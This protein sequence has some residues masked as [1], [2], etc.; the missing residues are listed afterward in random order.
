MKS[1]K[2]SKCGKIKSFDE[3]YDS[4]VYLDGKS[5][6][7]KNCLLDIKR[8]YRL[9]KKGI[10]ETI[11][12]NQKNSCRRRKH[13][14]PTYTMKE[15]ELWLFD[16][17][18]FH[19]LYDGWV[20]SGY[21][22]W[23]KPSVDRIDDKKSYTMDNI[24]LMIFKE[25]NSKSHKCISNGDYDGYCT[26]VAQYDLDGNFIAEYYSQAQ[27]ERETG[28][29]HISCVCKGYRNQSGGYKWKYVK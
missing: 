26:K 3:F 13:P 18:L 23:M 8:K 25:N 16:Q 2:C 4:N 7:C 12:H 27:A 6:A 24:Q 14:T 10:V 22:R 28:A 19:K 11:Y 29:A 1:K 17:K 5:C 21:D 9:T 15:L 20:E